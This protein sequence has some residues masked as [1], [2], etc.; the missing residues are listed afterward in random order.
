M[1]THTH[2]MLTPLTQASPPQTPTATRPITSPSSQLHSPCSRATSWRMTKTTRPHALT[3]STLRAPCIVGSRRIWGVHRCMLSWVI[4]IRRLTR[5]MCRIRFNRNSYPVNLTGVMGIWQSRCY[6][7]AFA[8]AFS[9]DALCP[10]FSLW[11]TEG[12]ISEQ[13]ANVT[14]TTCVPTPPLVFLP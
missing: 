14:R 7:L 8:L 1:H 4:M 6:T 12:W 3:P 13:V 10:P 9:L 11:E 2:T 5:L